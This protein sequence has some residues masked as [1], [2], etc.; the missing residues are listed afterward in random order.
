MRRLSDVALLVAVASLL[1]GCSSDSSSSS[2]PDV[3]VPVVAVDA[4]LIQLG[5]YEVG[6]VPDEFVLGPVIVVYGDGS[7]H[8][9]LY[10][11]VENGEASLRLVTGQLSESHLRDVFDAAASLPAPGVVGEQ[12][13]DGA[14]MLLRVGSQ[15]WAINDVSVQPYRQFMDD[16]IAL[17]DEEVTQPWVPEQWIVKPFG[18][19]CKV[20]AENPQAGPYDAPVYPH[21]QAPC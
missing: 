14:P 11:G 6:G 21:L 3:T 2:S 15:E 13:T 12:A 7:V 10:V 5:S 1:A 18:E 16:L 19:P 4:V 9:E 20:V 17:V 8:A